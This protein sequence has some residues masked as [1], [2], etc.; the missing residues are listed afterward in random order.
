MHTV[1]TFSQLMTNSTRVVLACVLL[2]LAASGTAGAQDNPNQGAISLSGGFDLL[3]G[4][5]YVFRGIV[6]ESDPGLTMWPYGE[7]SIALTEGDG[8]VKSSAVSIGVWNSLHTGSSGSDGPSKKAWYE[9]DFYATLSLGLG[10]GFGLD[11]TY[12][13]YTSPN[14]S[15][16]TVN[17]LSF[18]VSM[19]HH[20]APYALLAFEMSKDG[21][22]DGGEKAGTYLELGVGPA[23]PVLGGMMD[24][25]FPVKLGLSLNNYYELLG[26][27]GVFQDKAFGF[28]SVGVGA[29]LPLQSVPAR[30]GS[31]DLHAEAD[32]LILGD[33]TEAV[34]DGDNV[35]GTFLVGVGLSY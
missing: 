9:G 25:S 32:V 14:N 35:K 5:A 15:F 1:T 16:S 28:F 3:P 29:S 30:Y 34:N 33:A 21:Q 31:W 6:Q 10:R 27:D 18:N 22:A 8:G 13:A 19:E 17:E 12:T 26:D 24:V 11:T 20:L 23:Y 7:L 2:T 4:T